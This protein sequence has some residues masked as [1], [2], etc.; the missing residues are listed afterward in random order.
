LVLL[1]TFN[2]FPETIK[3]NDRASQIEAFALKKQAMYGDY[4][5]NNLEKVDPA[6]DLIDEKDL[7]D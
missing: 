7:Y 3:F 5:M 6:K 2:S 4:S 1:S